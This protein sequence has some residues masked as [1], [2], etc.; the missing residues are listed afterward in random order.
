MEQ[1]MLSVGIDIGTSTT[2]VIF[3]RLTL[4]DTG[5]FGSVPS[6]AITDKKILYRTTPEE[7]PL[8]PNDI[9]D[10][11]GVTVIVERAYRDAGFH[12]SDPDTGAVII[13]GET[14]AKRNAK[15]VLHAISHIAG[16][17]V[18]AVAGPSLEG[19]LAG[20]GS[21]AQALSCETGKIVAN[22]DV[23]GGTTN[24]CLFE[25]GNVL[26][27]SCLNLGGRILRINTG[28][29]SGISAN[30]SPLSNILSDPVA[31]GNTADVK[32]L[33]A[34][35]DRM[36]SIIASALGLLPAD[37]LLESVIT[38]HP[39]TC[40]KVPQ[41]IMFSGGVAECMRSSKSD[42]AYNDLGVL[43]ARS[44]MNI[45]KMAVITVPA[46]ETENATVIG[47]GNFSVD[48]SGSTVLYDDGRFPMTGIPVFRMKLEDEFSASE[49][50]DEIAKCRKRADEYIQ[51]DHQWALSFTGPAC[52]SFREIELIADQFAACFSQKDIPIL[53]ME[54]DIAKALGQALRRRIGRTV[55]IDGICCHDGD[56]LDIGKPLSIGK[57]LPVIVRTLVFE[58]RR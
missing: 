35:T 10:A 18:A 32:T 38:D 58:S 42:F 50:I 39:L 12:A 11:D 25:D 36:S 43:L 48:V 7:T 46:E 15:Q 8:L 56:Y 30:F 33:S 22:L 29:I 17:F 4:E 31:I 26:D 51:T 37:P 28:R 9:I 44:L 24:I 19:I 14:A 40:R 27:T 34:L 23:G 53:V 41:L 54:S 5:G 13:T 57:A 52:P 3:S 16:S 47:A 45:R 21:G 55:C 1:H 6:I 49:I 20:K 2:Q